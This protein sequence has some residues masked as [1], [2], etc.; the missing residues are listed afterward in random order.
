MIAFSPPL[1]VTALSGVTFKEL[2]KPSGPEDS[3][4]VVESK[5]KLDPTECFHLSIVYS[6]PVEVNQVPL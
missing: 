2:P 4:V 3:C 6:S 1:G 5:L